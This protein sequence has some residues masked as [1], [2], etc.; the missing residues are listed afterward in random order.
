MKEKLMD[1][2]I[3]LKHR[4]LAIKEISIEVSKEEFADMEEQIQNYVSI[5]MSNAPRIGFDVVTY[6]YCGIKFHL[7]T[8]EQ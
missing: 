2:A 1:L 7:K 8:T 3:E 4:G 5:S 6:V